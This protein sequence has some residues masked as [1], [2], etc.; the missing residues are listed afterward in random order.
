MQWLCA[1]RLQGF[2]EDLEKHQAANNTKHV[3]GNRGT[4]APTMPVARELRN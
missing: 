2:G 3:V 4:K 1:G